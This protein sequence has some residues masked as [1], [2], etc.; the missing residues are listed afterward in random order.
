MRPEILQL[1]GITAQGENHWAARG[2]QVTVRLFAHSTTP[3][4][5]G[6]G[7]YLRARFE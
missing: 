4:D 3:L 7:F 2:E 6:N 1:S 5:N